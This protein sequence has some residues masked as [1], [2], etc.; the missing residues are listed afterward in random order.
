MVILLILEMR[1]SYFIK[2]IFKS[3]YLL[4]IFKSFFLMSRMLNEVDFNKTRFE[5]HVK[6]CVGI[7]L[8][9]FF[10]LLGFRACRTFV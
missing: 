6:N 5:A 2:V 7:L 10:S 4:N 3:F 1:S 9:T 8:E